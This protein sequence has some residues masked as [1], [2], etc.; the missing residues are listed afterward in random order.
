VEAHNP[1]QDMFGFP[2]LAKLLG[3]W[4]ADQ[5]LI[6]LLLRDLA[7]FTGPDWEQEDDVTLV[8][9]TRSSGYG[10]SEIATRSTTRAEETMENDGWRLLAEGSVPSEPGNERLA[11]AQVTEAVAPLNLPARRLAELQTAVGEATMNAMEHGNRY[12]SDKPVAI[13]VLSSKTAVVV[14]IID[15]GGGQNIPEPE[16]P[17][18]E[19]KLEGLQT[20]RGWGLFLIKN[21]VDEMRVSSDEHHHTI[22]LIVHLPEKPQTSN[23]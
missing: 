7:E 3:E 15:H 18:L 6:D 14:R 22:E 20:P 19:A 17:D 11:I 4:H 1:E 5:D 12:Q 10:R 23:T 16:T 13:Q 8:T 2:R 9:L 21:L